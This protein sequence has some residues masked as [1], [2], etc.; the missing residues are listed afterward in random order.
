[1][2]HTILVLG[3]RAQLTLVQPRFD[4]RNKA[5]AGADGIPLDE[6]ALMALRIDEVQAQLAKCTGKHKKLNAR[7]GVSRR[8]PVAHP[9]YM[10]TK[11]YVEAYYALNFP[12]SEKGDGYGVADFFEPLSTNTQAWPNDPLH[13]V[14]A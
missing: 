12:D 2:K 4:W 8:Y 10:N 3:T 1:M 6:A 9:L 5:H 11:T 14:D 7:G 13:E